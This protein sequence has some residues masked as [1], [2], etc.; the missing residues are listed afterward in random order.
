MVEF[1]KL[2]RGDQ[3]FQQFEKD[4]AV[5][6]E[7]AAVIAERSRNV[8]PDGSWREEPR[9]P[10]AT[11]ATT[12][13]LRRIEAHR[14]RGREVF[15]P[16]KQPLDLDAPHTDAMGRPTTGRPFRPVRTRAD[17]PP[18]RPADFHAD[19][20]PAGLRG[21]R[22]PAVAGQYFA[23]SLGF[24]LARLETKLP[25]GYQQI[26]NAVGGAGLIVSGVVLMVTPGGQPLG[27]LMIGKGLDDAIAGGRS[28]AASRNIRTLT[29]E[30][31]A[32]LAAAARLSRGGT[33]TWWG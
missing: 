30:V 5:K 27:V 24:S 3:E 19:G 4:R 2:I 7:K 28:V 8:R 33:R 17:G 10:A 25:P 26:L 20:R 23:A 15:P 1:I 21:A 18:E 9:G 12:P 11:P 14:R 13:C 6:D 16:S 31:T 22:R 32:R 29:A